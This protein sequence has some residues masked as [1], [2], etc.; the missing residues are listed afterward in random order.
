MNHTGG[1]G[2]RGGVG[3]DSVQHGVARHH[4]M[5]G[6]GWFIITK[7]VVALVDTD[8]IVGPEGA[9]MGWNWSA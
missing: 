6:S 7:W 2:G 9:C 3:S 5:C 4:A 1:R 8:C